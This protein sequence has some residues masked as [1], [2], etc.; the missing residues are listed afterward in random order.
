MNNIQ[1]AAPA[2][3]SGNKQSFC[4]HEKLKSENSHWSYVFAVSPHTANAKA[5]LNTCLLDKPEFAVYERV[6]NYFVLVDF[7]NDYGSLND[8]AKKII[9][10]NPKAKAS[11]LGWE[12]HSFAWSE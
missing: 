8:A 3:T 4:I 2:T 5:Q 11:I 7:A 9:D 6:G 12:K 10:S 1:S